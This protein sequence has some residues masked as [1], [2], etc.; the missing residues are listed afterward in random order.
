MN[1][2]NLII[3]SCHTVCTHLIGTYMKIGLCKEK[4]THAA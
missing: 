1:A 4:F 2:V 3:I